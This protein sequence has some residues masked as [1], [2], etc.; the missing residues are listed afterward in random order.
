MTAVPDGLSTLHQKSD[1]WFARARASL[2]GELPCRQGCCRCCHGTFA[3]TRLDAVEIQ[4]GLDG[5]EP[6]V[7]ADIQL[8]AARQRSQIESAFPQLQASV[9]L[10]AWPDAVLDDVAQRFR[11]LP[12][13]ALHADGSCRVYRFRP[14]TCRM[15]GIPIE[16]GQT[17]EG[18]CDVQTA[19]PIKRLPRV[20][21]EEES[22]LAEQE[23]AELRRPGDRPGCGDEVLL[24]YGF[25]R[26]WPA[27][28]R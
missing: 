1:E 12:C 2:L 15:M 24:P 23:A 6:S 5:L 9:S 13:P 7:R 8:R 11:D 21:R 28:P 3:I 4:R 27:R 25:L 19:I 18:A 26:D 14:V 17:S 16:S 10:D 20:L 22:R